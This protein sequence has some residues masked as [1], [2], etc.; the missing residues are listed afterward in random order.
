MTISRRT[1][2]NMLAASGAAMA[3]PAS[4]LAR[5][6]WTPRPE[7]LIPGDAFRHGVA[8]GDP[9]K[10]RVILWT[11]VTP[12]SQHERIPV[13]CRI[14]K[15]PKMNDVISHYRAFASADTDF[16]VKIDAYGLKPDQT[17]YYQ[18]YAR[19]EASPIGRTRTLPHETDN[20]R[21]G[22]VSCANLPAGFFGAYGL[23]AQQ[24]N[25]NAIVHLGDY[26]YEYANGTYGDG[27][28]IG[29]IPEPN[30]ETVTLS[31]YRTRL[32]QYRRDAQLQEAHRLHPWIMVWDDHE[33]ANDAYKDGA[34]NH[35]ADEGDWEVRKA[36]ALKAYFEWLPV[37]DTSGRRQANA[38]IF[39]RFRFG[40]LVQLD[41]LDTR[42]FGREQQ[43]P[44]LI[45]GVTPQLLVTP[46]ELFYYLSEINR[47][48][49]QLLGEKQEQWLFRQMEK[50]TEKNTQW[51][52]LGQQVM[53]GQLS[54][55][56]AGLPP[57]VR[58]PLNTDQWDGYAGARQR[59][60]S[61][62]QTHNLDNT[63]ILAGDFHSSWA[64]DISFNPYDSAVYDPA[65]GSG[66]IAV[67]FV[68]P[69]VSSPFFVDLDPAFVKGLEQ[70][71]LINNPHTK[72][73]DLENNG[74]MVV[75]IDRYR[76]RAEYYHLHNV[77][78]PDTGETLAAAVETA[79]A[80]NHAVLVE[81]QV[82]A[83]HSKNA[84][85]TA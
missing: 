12:R 24:Y 42:L 18:F 62:L 4:V 55:A 67:E 63:I 65:S 33:F 51:H 74:Y 20:I 13:K 32:S 27:T 39:R 5:S 58:I 6:Q 75:D 44:Q 23:L 9:L 70:F 21:L 37:R 69:A 19:G 59:I 45:D 43:T 41:M 7:D 16:T 28:D 22:V 54:V 47:A 80:Q 31:D 40:D 11:R 77:L 26:T 46:D 1:F 3:V 79:T 14:A 76:A 72:Y 36:A 60:L 52:V 84:V 35:Q 78:N 56:S 50:A 8:S 73:V 82:A 85:V 83:L 68:G 2:L 81:G 48:D 49:R 38:V 29:R 71:A 64:N 10:H 30:K 17:Y 57:G 66:S 25:L 15:D 53:M 61:L 34:E